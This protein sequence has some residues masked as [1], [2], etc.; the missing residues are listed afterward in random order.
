MVQDG[1]LD[2]IPV[3]EGS[4]IVQGLKNMTWHKHKH[5]TQQHIVHGLFLFLLLLLL[6]F[7]FILSLKIP[8]P[9]CND[10]CVPQT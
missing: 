9:G 2:G 1:A 8:S 3:I 6:L 5:R 7:L 10:N 4:L